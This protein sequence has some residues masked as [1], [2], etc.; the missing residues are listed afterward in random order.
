MIT[1]ADY[2]IAKQNV[3]EWTESYA[4]YDEIE[5]TLAAIAEY[6]RAQDGKA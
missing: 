6:E 2:E 5:G 3:L 1:K 4:S